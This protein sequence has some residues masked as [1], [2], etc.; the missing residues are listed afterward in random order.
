MMKEKSPVIKKYRAFFVELQGFEPW[1]KQAAKLLS[2]CL[3][4]SW[5]FG[6]EP[7]KGDPILSLSFFDF[8]TGTEALPA[9]SRNFAMLPKGR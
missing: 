6:F 7:G 1:S 5:Y 3:S 4:F 9:L 8:R 2:T